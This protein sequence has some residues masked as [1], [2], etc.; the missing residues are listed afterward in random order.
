M[1]KG[2]LTVIA[3]AVV[4]AA[5]VLVIV[6]GVTGGDEPIAAVPGGDP[7]RGERLVE[8]YGCDAC[9][10]LP[11]IASTNKYVGPPLDDFATERFIAGDEPN[12]LDVLIRWIMN[13]QRIEPGTLMPNLGV[14]RADARDIA[15]YLYS[16]R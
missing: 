11:G 12:R 7:D 16:D 10:T 15:A 2:A 6:L 5:A 4:A 1:S 9:H 13:P 14:S 8:E 3:V